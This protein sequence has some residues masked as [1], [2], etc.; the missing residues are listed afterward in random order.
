MRGFCIAAL[1]LVGAAGTAVAEPVEAGKKPSPSFIYL[2][3]AEAAVPASGSV[4]R[5]SASIIAVGEPGVENIKVAAVGSKSRRGAVP[6]VIR[7]G[8]V[9]SAFTAP[10]APAVALPTS[11][12]KTPEQVPASVQSGAPEA[13][14]ADKPQ[15][16]NADQPPADAVEKQS[17]AEPA[18]EASSPR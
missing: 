9:G 6:M 14:S 16:V 15:E 12:A 18:A 5:S 17:N 4:S 1:M 2:G 13:A 7:G 8:I 10:P 3:K 11:D